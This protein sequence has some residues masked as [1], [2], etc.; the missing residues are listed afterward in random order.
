MAF[1]WLVWVFQRL[2]PPA[3]VGGCHRNHGLLRAPVCRA[4]SSYISQP[5]GTVLGQDAEG[6]RAAGRLARENF[7]LLFGPLFSPCLALE[8]GCRPAPPAP[9]P[10]QDSVL[11]VYPT[12]PQPCVFLPLRPLRITALAL[13]L[14]VYAVYPCATQEPSCARVPVCY[15][16]TWLF[17]P[18]ADP[19]WL[20]SSLGI[21]VD[22][23]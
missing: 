23:F 21:C 6:G 8:K 7:R 10:Q 16:H 20:R 5:L 4:A 1:L 15:T 19:P 18:I 22:P 3:E 12:H 17:S 13:D 9:I 14:S 2:P 11:C